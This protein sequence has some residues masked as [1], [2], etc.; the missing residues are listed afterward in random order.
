MI[1]YVQT[2]YSGSMAYAARRSPWQIFSTEC[3]ASSGPKL[4]GISYKRVISSTK[5]TLRA[6]G[7]TM[8][9]LFPFS[10]VWFSVVFFLP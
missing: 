8:Q 9:M 10:S 4:P 5:R 7:P 3:Y 1:S 2:K 6:G